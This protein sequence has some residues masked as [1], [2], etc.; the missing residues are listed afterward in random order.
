MYFSGA[1]SQQVSSRF[2]KNLTQ[3]RN[4]SFD[5]ALFTTIVFVA[6][7]GN[8]SAAKIYE[9]SDKDVVRFAGKAFYYR[10]K[11]VD[12]DGNTTYSRIVKLII[13]KDGSYVKLLN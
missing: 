10:I 11:Q 6:A 7:S 3:L 8:S 13:P 12:F 1:Y 2:L 4:Q 9:T 5:G